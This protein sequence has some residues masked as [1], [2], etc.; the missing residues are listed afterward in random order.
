MTLIKFVQDLVIPLGLRLQALRVD[1]AG[2]YIGDYYNDYCKNTAIILRFSSSN[3]P[4]QNGL[5]EWD[6]PT[7]MDVARCLLNE[8]ALPKSL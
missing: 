5:S 1:S 8:A 4:K 3:T 6:G 7:I 2:D